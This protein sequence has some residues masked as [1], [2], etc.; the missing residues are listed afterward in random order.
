MNAP[1]KTTATALLGLVLDGSRLDFVAVK[2]TNGSVEVRHSASATLTLDPLTN[3]PDLV[4]AE[5]QTHLEK[6]GVR[7]RQGGGC[8]QGTTGQ[9][10]SDSSLRKPW[11]SGVVGARK[12]VSAVARS[13]RRP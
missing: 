6:A 7:D 4:G 12:K 8:E 5:I 9:L 11:A 1:K 3:E 10:H 13:T 2:R